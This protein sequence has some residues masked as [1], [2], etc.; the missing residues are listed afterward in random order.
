MQ[1]P[2]AGTRPEDRRVGDRPL[3]RV[4]RRAGRL[5]ARPGGACEFKQLHL[6]LG[7]YDFAP[8]MIRDVV[9]TF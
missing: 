4:P 6:E 8:R 7:A 1:E 2:I 9:R 5:L 3:L